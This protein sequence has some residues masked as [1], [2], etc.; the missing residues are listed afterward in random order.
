MATPAILLPVLSTYF[1]QIAQEKTKWLALNQLSL[2]LL[3]SFITSVI[4]R[5]IILQ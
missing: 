4:L 5:L 2:I 3:L 1:G